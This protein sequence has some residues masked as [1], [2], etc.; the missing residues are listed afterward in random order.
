MKGPGFLPEEPFAPWSIKK[1]VCDYID[2]TYTEVKSRPAYRCVF[3]ASNVLG[4]IAFI[5]LLLVPAAYEGEMYIIAVVLLA[6][7]G[8]CAH[9][10]IKEDGQIK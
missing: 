2:I 1:G 8:G 4:A 6:V 3:N 7:F 9:L 10:S 5:A